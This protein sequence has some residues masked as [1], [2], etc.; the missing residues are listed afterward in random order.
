MIPQ[1]IVYHKSPNGW[2]RK[3][4]VGAQS[5]SAIRGAIEQLKA[6]VAPVATPRIGR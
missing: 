6:S 2:Q 4:L 5:I 1:L 3:Q